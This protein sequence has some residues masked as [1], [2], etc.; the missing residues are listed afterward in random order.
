MSRDDFR[1]LHA[2]ECWDLCGC[3]GEP[4]DEQGDCLTM[5]CDNYLCATERVLSPIRD[6]REIRGEDEAF[7]KEA[8]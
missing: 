7:V 6:T 5:D 8:S 2:S 4:L 1:P 3:C